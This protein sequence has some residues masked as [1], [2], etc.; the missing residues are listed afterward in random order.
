MTDNE[1]RET[2]PSPARTGQPHPDNPA[3]NVISLRAHRRRPAPVTPII[4]TALDDP[5]PDPGPSAA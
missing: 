5:D 4:R 1:R 2:A 3:G